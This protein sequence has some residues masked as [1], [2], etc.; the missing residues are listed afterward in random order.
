M[1]R[2]VRWLL[3][4]GVVTLLAVVLLRGRGPEIAPGSV[5][6]VDL[7]GDYIEAPE[8]PLV[9]RLLGTARRPLAALLSELGKAERDE[10]LSAVHFRIRSLDL[11]WGKAQ[12]LRGAIERLRE[13]G[14]HTVAWLEIEKFGPNLEYYVASAADEVWMAPGARNPL[15]GLAA[16]HLFLGGLFEKIGVEVEYERVGAYKSAVETIS[17][18][19]MSEANREMSTAILDSLDGQF[20]RGIAAG[21]KLD[22][23]RVREAIDAAPTSP[24]EMLAHGLVDGVGFHDEIL[25]KAGDPEVVEATEYAAVDPADVGFA[26]EASFALVY[27]SGPV[28]SGTGTSSRRGAPV[29]ASRTVAKAIADAA[30]D[31]GIRAIVL[32]VDSPGGSALASD[33]VW[34]AMRRARERGKPVVAS[35]SDVAASGG[36]YVACG[37]DKVV[38]EPGTLTGSIGVFVLRPVLAGAFEKLGIGVESMT[39]GAHADLLLSTR[40]LSP[41]TRERVR[42]DVEGVY[43]LFVE[44]VAE[45]RGLGTEA[46][47]AVGR[48]RVFTGEQARENGLVDVLGGLRTAVV[49]AKRAAGLAED[50]D[51]ALVPYP[52]PRPLIEQLTEAAALRM[53]EA[54][55]WLPV[56]AALQTLA[57]TLSAL[58]SGAALVIPPVLPQVR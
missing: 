45:G 36:Y 39:R 24:A 56:P 8:E 35:F 58:P 19:K 16:E 29:L 52:P 13:R 23:A 57:D 38:A 6:V 31:D 34:R 17:E 37:A 53:A 12:E 4:L 33:E 55:S 21:R 22:E 51:V 40:P 41:G 30:E 7:E 46:V 49:E 44:R 11:G 47:D 9:A 2:R 50:A 18:T 26:P 20:V 54:G 28:V 27:G 32:R 5:L 15:V 1:K 48:G 25:K 42:A 43:R 10:R 14:R 3:V